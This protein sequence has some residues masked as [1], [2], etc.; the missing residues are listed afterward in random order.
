MVSRSVVQVGGGSFS[1][2]EAGTGEPIVYAHGFPTSGYLWRDV[3]AETSKSFHAIAPDFPGYGDSDLLSGPH[4]WETLMRWLGEFVDAIGLDTFH[5]AV[6]DWGGLIGLGWA[7]QNPQRVSSLLITDTSFRSRDRWHAAARQWR[8]P[9]VG[10]ELFGSLTRDG[11]KNLLSAVTSIPDDAIDEYW[12]G[13]SDPARRAAKLEMYRSLEFEMLTPLEPLLKEVAPGRVRVIWG[14]NDPFVPP[15]IGTGMAEVLE[16]EITIIAGA[17]HFL[18]EDAGADVGR[19][20]LDFLKS[21][22]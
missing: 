15:K 5:L 13:L 20:H 8:T 7:S 3:M 22:A 21:Q 1:Y 14:E 9:G 19:L 4:T 16:A 11:L 17:S 10:E 2:R 6:H 12:K 18:Q